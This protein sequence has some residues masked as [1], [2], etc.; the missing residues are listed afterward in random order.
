MQ[1]MVWSSAG[2]GDLYMLEREQF[3]NLASGGAMAQL[4]PKLRVARC[5]RA[6]ST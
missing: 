2:Q 4:T 3:Q 6:I 5:Q 1:L